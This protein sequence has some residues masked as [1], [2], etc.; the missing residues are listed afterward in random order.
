M[1][2]TSA[3]RNDN[4]FIIT[5]QLTFGGA[6]KDITSATVTATMRDGE[7]PLTVLDADHAVTITTPSTSLVTLTYSDTELADIPTRS[8]FKTAINHNVFFKI[9]ESGGGVTHSDSVT[10]PFIRKGV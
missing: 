2:V 6:T 8:D 9:V 7:H 4:D 10:V 3:V 5:V 1:P